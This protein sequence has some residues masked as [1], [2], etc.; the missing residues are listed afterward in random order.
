MDK[1]LPTPI[2]VEYVPSVQLREVQKVECDILRKLLEVCKKHNLSIWVNSGTL[3][4]AIRHRGFI[5]WD[6]DVDLVMLR[7][8]YDKL[9]KIGPDEFKEPYFFQ[10]A[11]TDKDY[12]FPHAQIRRSDTTAILPHTKRQKFNQGIFVDIFVYDAVLED[13][14]AFAKQCKRISFMQTLMYWRFYWYTAKNWYTRL[15]AYIY[16]LCVSFV[17][18]KKWYQKMEDCLRK[19]LELPYSYVAAVMFSNKNIQDRIFPLSDFQETIWVP[20]E[21]IEVPVQSGYDFMLRKMYGDDYMT[22]RHEPTMHGDGIFFDT[23]KPYTYYMNKQ[24]S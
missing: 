15:A 3:L 10:T 1:L 19:N 21:G 14:K 22:P 18:H 17:N 2:S 5:P 6:D 11:Y 20:Y 8:D 23:E 13:S 16:H 4:G 7:D 12:S 24:K 9:L